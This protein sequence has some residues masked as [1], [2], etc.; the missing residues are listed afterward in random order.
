[1][2][3]SSIDCGLLTRLV[4]GHDDGGEA[5]AGGKLLRL[6]ETLNVDNAVV[7]VTRWYGGSQ[8][9]PDRFRHINEAAR[10]ALRE[11]QLLSK[12]TGKNAKK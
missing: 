8:L 5:Q 3:R 6:L 9:G 2:A 12:P 11:T 7:V 10:D 1:M 4:A